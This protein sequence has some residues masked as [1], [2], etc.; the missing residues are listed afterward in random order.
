MNGAMSISDRPRAVIT[1]AGGGLGRAF[2]LEL[3]RRGS[4]LVVSDVRTDAAE[5]TAS[6]VRARGAEAHVVACDVRSAEEFG[7]LADEA[8]ERLGAVDLL[9]NNAGVAVGGQVGEIPL[10]DW[11]WIVDINLM[12]VVHGCHLFAPRMKARRSG[13]IINIA[14]AAGLVASPGMAPYHATKFAVVGLSESLYSELK[15]LG[16]GV[17]VVCPTFFPTG[18]IDAGRGGDPMM[19]QIAR[20]RMAASPLDSNDVARVAL[21]AADRDRLFCVPMAD[22]RAMWALKR[23]S[24]EQ[25][26]G[27]VAPLVLK[28]ARGR[29]KK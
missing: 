8:E 6:L 29:V 20:Q 25:W 21:E 5:E 16:V 15:P 3:A 28:F 23:L 7:K 14:S 13:H 17:T 9:V 19:K 24:P 26:Y 4:R 18:I 11:R 22:G 10:E 12:G 27:R 2:C 1:G